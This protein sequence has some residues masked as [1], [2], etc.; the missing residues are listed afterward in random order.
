MFNESTRFVCNFKCMFFVRIFLIGPLLTF[1]LSF[2]M[3]SKSKLSCDFLT[4]PC[5]TRRISLNFINCTTV[6]RFLIGQSSYY[7]A[8]F[9]MDYC[10]ASWGWIS[11]KMQC[12]CF[13]GGGGGETCL[14]ILILFT[15][16][17]LLWKSSHHIW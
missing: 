7:I 2:F 8:N 10:Q 15:R 5:D 1:S 13:G 14:T 9:M 16:L 11:W 3:I 12:I 4:K 17:V 6:S